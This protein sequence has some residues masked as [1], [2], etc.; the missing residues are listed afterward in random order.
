MKIKYESFIPVS[1]TSV[2]NCFQD[3]IANIGQ[4]TGRGFEM[5]FSDSWRFEFDLQGFLGQGGAIGEHMKVEAEYSNE[6]FQKYHGIAVSHLLA[7]PLNHKSFAEVLLNLEEGFPL[8]ILIDNYIIPW[9]KD[10]LKTHSPH[11]IMPIGYDRDTNTV[12]CIDPIFSKNIEV[13]PADLLNEYNLREVIYKL[14]V[15]EKYEEPSLMDYIQDIKSLSQRIYSENHVEDIASLSK[16]IGESGFDVLREFSVDESADFWNCAL[17]LSL[18][19][20][21]F[22]RHYF[23]K[24]LN[25]ASLRYRNKDF[26]FLST[27]AN[28]ICKQWENIRLLL[29][30]AYYT[31]KINSKDLSKRLLNIAVL[32]EQFIDTLLNN[33]LRTLPHP[34]G[35]LTPPVKRASDIHVNL[36]IEHLFNNKGFAHNEGYNADFTGLGEF[37]MESH[38]A[39]NAKK[40]T[41]DIQK[42]FDNISCAAETIILPPEK[43]GYYDFIS[44]I[45]CAEW[46]DCTDSLQVVYEDNEVILF[47]L[48][49]TDWAAEKP[50]FGE[51]VVWEGICGNKDKEKEPASMKVYI[52]DQ[53]IKISKRKKIKEIKLPQCPNIHIFSIELIDSQTR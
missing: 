39:V 14:D 4:L 13:L 28:S 20:V 17:L 35:S 33:D 41:P 1:D 34:T 12:Q 7:N 29:F 21:I 52:Y 27:E 43:V 47:P 44:I 15:L 46:G 42:R 30:K 19:R 36:N 38:S 48:N 9:G 32:E 37:L 31:K 26:Y 23:S 18:R 50:R 40:F 6:Y 49:I 11:Y 24:I 51:E 10:Y 22:G 2:H 25:S 8:I 16:L 3:L 5:F 45:G 53:T